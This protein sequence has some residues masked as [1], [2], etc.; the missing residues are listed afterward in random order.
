[1][2]GSLFNL[3]HIDDYILGVRKAMCQEIDQIPATEI[4]QADVDQ[5]A[6]KF[7]EKYQVVCPVLRTDEI[8][9]DQPPFSRGN[10]TV[11]IPVYV[12]FTGEAELFKYTGGSAPLIYQTIQVQPGQLVIPMQ[13][14]R[15]KIAELV[16][17]VTDLLKRV[18]EEGLRPI[19]Q[20]LKFYN[21]DLKR[22]A[23]LRIQERQVEHASHDRLIGDL[24]KTGFALRRRNDGNERIIVPV[25]PRVI[26]IQ[27]A[28]GPA[29]R[30]PE[31]PLADYDEILSVIRSMVTVFERSPS[32]F[33]TMEEE[34][35]RTILLVALNGLFKGNATAETFNGSGK[36]DILIRV[37]DNN[38]FIAEC[39]IWDG[40]EHFR[41]KLLEQLFDYSTWRDSKLA[42]II[43]NRKRDFSAVVQKMRAVAAGL[44]NV[45]AEMTYPV[46]TACRH[47]MRRFDDPHK[48]FIL[49]CMAF[50]V[51]S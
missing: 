37:N 35:L 36:T 27:P 47:R 48:E 30:E 39:L 24:Q 2:P 4:V 23:A 46:S 43:F 29:A 26:A 16:T 12:P 21:T 40:Q 50:E 10:D 3:G 8:S 44:S 5:L 7:S 6:T 13:M 18:S 41:G 34:H 9:Y 25:K 32:V 33:K 38:I 17:K 19:E 45:V 20:K 42:A 15:T 49:T 11:T 22:W 14:E 51:P 28:T 1:M 31:L